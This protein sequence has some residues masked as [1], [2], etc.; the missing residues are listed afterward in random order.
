MANTAYATLNSRL[1]DMLC[2]AFV[3]EW[4]IIC[5]W[6]KHFKVFAIEHT[7]IFYACLTPIK[8][9]GDYFWVGQ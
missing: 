3:V 9:R 5:C 8:A 6:T 1:D 4:G 7:V 2:N